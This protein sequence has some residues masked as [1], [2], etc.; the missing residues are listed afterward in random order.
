MSARTSGLGTIDFAD[1]GQ[2]APGGHKEPV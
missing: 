2:P 1:C